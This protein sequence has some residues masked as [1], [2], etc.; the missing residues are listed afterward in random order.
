MKK[1]NICPL[2]LLVVILSACST[3]GN[4]VSTFANP[5]GNHSQFPFL[6]SNGEEL[7]MSWITHHPNEKIYSLNYARYASGSWSSVQSIAKDSSWFVNWADFPSV[8]ADEQGLVAAHWLNKIPGGTYAY[9]VNISLLT[10]G[11]WTAPVT[12][13][14]D[15]TAT[16]HGFVSMVPWGKETVLAVW[17]DGRESAFRSDE[18]YYNLEK[19]MTLRGAL[20]SRSGEVLKS[21]IIDDA[22]CD[23]CQTSLV[24]TPNGAI[25][26]YRNRTN[27]EVRDIYVSRFNG[28]KWTKPEAVFNDHWKIGACPV[29]G[30]KLASKDSLVVV[31]WPTA[32]NMN[33]VVKASISTDGGLSF[34]QPQIVSNSTSLGRVDAAIYQGDVFISWIEKNGEETLLKL[35]KIDRNGEPSKTILVSTINGSRKTGFPQLEMLDDQLIMAWTVISDS[36]NHVKTMKIK[37]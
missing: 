10:D 35:K 14:F 7:Y 12:P 2:L 31:A 1:Q 28:E 24:K 37:V 29:N 9:N 25:V 20:I 3:A 13:H 16:E 33:P 4:K 32:A 15:N 18:E 30:P 21:F 6:F 11:Q 26:A 17:L 34:S 19:A 22:V 5:A 23:C 8:T 36:T 27:N